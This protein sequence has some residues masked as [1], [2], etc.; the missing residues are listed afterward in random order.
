M[1]RSVEELQRMY[2]AYTQASWKTYQQRAFNVKDTTRGQG[3][4]YRRLEIEPV[5]EVNPLIKEALQKGHSVLQG[6]ESMNETREYDAPVQNNALAVPIKVRGQTI[7]AIEVQL[8]GQLLTPEI[9]STY[10][11]I[12]SR[13][14]LILENARLLQDAQSLARREQQINVL[15]S[16]IRNSI[17]L[18]TILQNTVRELGKAF[19]SARTFIH[20]GVNAK[21]LEGTDGGDHRNDREYRAGEK[22]GTI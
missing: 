6:A 21:E 15:S 5:V 12:A 14:A 19:G 17:N 20:L 3:Y 16:E 10:E 2:G 4:R 9:V 13:L 18:D 1:E 11:E 22:E 7:G 8:S